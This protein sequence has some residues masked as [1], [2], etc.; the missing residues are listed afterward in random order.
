LKYIFRL[1]FFLLLPFATHAQLTVVGGLTA[2][3]MANIIAG[4]GITTSNAIY[5]GPAISS[6]SFNGSASNIGITSGVLLTCGD[7]NMAIG[8]NNLGSQGVDNL[9]PGNSDLD[10]IAGASTYDAVELEFDFVSQ[11][12]NVSFRYVFGSEEYPEWVN[13][14]FN[15][16]FAFYISGPGIPGSVNIGVVPSTSLPV[17][18]DNINSGTNS[19]YYVNNAGGTT[20][21]YDGFTRVLTATKPVQACET[22]HLR[23]TIADGG[24]GI[25]DSGVFI[26]ENSLISNVVQI[27]ASTVTADSTAWEGCSDA[28]VNFTLG[29]LSPSPTVINYTIGGTATNGSDYNLLP[30]SVTIP[31][32][33]ASASFTITPTVDGTPEG[34][35]NVIISVQ[36]SICGYDTIMVYIDDLDPLTVTAYGDTSLCNG[37]GQATIYA[38]AGGG[39]GGYTY[40][41][42]NGAGINDTTTVAPGATTT[43]TVTVDDACG[44]SQVNDAV[45]VT[46]AAMPL[47]DAGPDVTYCAGDAVTLTAAGGTSYT[48]YKL[49]GNTLVGNTAV[50]NVNPVGNEDYYVKVTTSGCTDY[51]TLSVTEN[52]AALADAGLDVVICENDV[53]QLSA[54]GGVQYDWSPAADLD[55]ATI[56]NPTFS[57][58]ATTT[59]TVT[60]TDANGCVDTD[61]VDVTVNPLPPADAGADITI[62]LGFTTPLDGSGGTQYLWSPA[63]DL[64]DAT[65][66]APTFSGLVS[67]TYTLTVTDNNGCV[68]TDDVYID[69]MQNIPLADFTMPTQTCVN[70]DVTITF[71][72]TA[73]NTALFNWNFNGGISTAGSNEGPYTVYWATTGTKTVEC[74]VD[75]NGCGSDTITYDI[76]VFANP[77]PNAGADQ[78]LCSG[79][80]ISIG[81]ATVAGETYQW[82]PATYV[83]DATSAA[84]DLTPLNMTAATMVL[85]YVITVTSQNGCVAKDTTLITV[86]PIPIAN[87]V[88][89]VG[90]C[91]DI[92]SIDF[93]AGGV[94]GNTA[95]F[96]WDFGNFANPASSTNENPNGVVFSLPDDYQV[97]L[98]I[99]ENGCVSLPSVQTIEIFPM[100]VAEFSANP[101]EGCEPLDVFFTDLSDDVGSNL[102]YDWKFGDDSISNASNPRHTYINAGVYDVQ[103]TITTGD[104]C[105][106]TITKPNYIT[107]YPRPVA[108]FKATPETVS[109]FDPRIIFTD[110]ST[111][112]DS[113][114]YIIGETG[115]MIYSCNF[116]YHFEDTGYYL[117]TQYVYS[118]H[119]CKDTAVLNVYVRPEFTFYIPSAFSPNADL[120][121]DVFYGY[122]TFIKE[123]DLTILNR[124]GQMLFRSLDVNQGWD[125]FYQGNKAQED[126][127]VYKVNIIDING[128][129]HEFIGKVTLFR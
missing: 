94:Y 57:G 95:T 120:T 55:D 108:G 80:V 121:N 36:T 32:N 53:I 43:Y 20:I 119:G 127:Y 99:T 116:E 13:S 100:P 102:A 11:S 14:G 97:S 126:V 49:P 96:A 88:A 86:F 9:A 104:G 110:L 16:A 1:V 129:K 90:E 89:P 78:S 56:N 3:Q 46:I 41:W 29:T 45:T 113:C 26:E 63:T 98:I 10:G 91:F 79:D 35:E 44:V 83:S 74:I 128:E 66:A 47:A 48:W 17:T 19:Q 34:L 71:T 117:I 75:E 123:Y 118:T 115:D 101:L 107:V 103:L 5:T 69:V 105:S 64:D 28:I 33:T 22:Y 37:I 42:N 67:T 112:S 125:G 114:E 15:D 40:S 124:W 72:G 92:N 109:I 76:D 77:V 39:G 23:L 106:N 59:L 84:P 111:G 31:A 82:T 38:I 61:D 62:C 24:D 7:I 25:Y 54:A 122:G 68:A 73:S 51:D 60:V 18:I 93:L 21:Q 81:G 8:P 6:G 58:T 87:Y 4:P 2:T 70:T 30:G 12:S 85:P 65:L 27:S 50:V 52:P